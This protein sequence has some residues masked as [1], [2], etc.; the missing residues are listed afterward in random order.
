MDTVALRKLAQERAK[1]FLENEGEYRMGYIE[2]EQPHPLTR[3]L[4]QTYAESTEKGVAMLLS[5]DEEMAKRA[6]ELLLSDGYILFADAVRNTLKNG[7]RVIWSGCGSS[8]RLCMRLEN[9]WRNAMDKLAQMHPE[10]AAD[11]EAL[12][13]RVGSIMT[14]GDYAIIR[15]VECFEDSTNLGYKQAEG[16][17]LTEK[18][19][20]VGVTA[21]AETTSILGSAQCALDV[22][23]KVYMLICSKPGPMLERM[24]RVRKIYT[25][26]NC[27]YL[28]LP[29]GPM[30]LT[31]STRMQSSSFEQLTGAIALEDAV[32][33][34]LTAFGYTAAPT[35]HAW[36]G[37]AY[38]NLIAQLASEKSVAAI[39]DMTRLEESV[40]RAGSVLTMYAE[41]YMLDVMTDTT[42]RPP[43]F[44]T[45]PF[46]SLDMADQPMSWAFVKNPACETR[47]AWQR[48]FAR[49][50]RCIDWN[51]DQ[52]RALGLNQ[53]QIDRIPR[54]DDQALVRFC[55]GCEPLPEREN[56]PGS[57]AMWVGK[58]A[59]PAA[60]HTHA[61]RYAQKTEYTLDHAGLNIPETWMDIYEHLGMKI[62]LNTLSTG[63][64]ASMGRIDGNWMTCLAMSNKKL[65]DRSA[66]I[67]ADVCAIPYEQAMEECFYSSL[68][69][70]AQN[71][72]TPLS[73]AQEA[74]RRL[75]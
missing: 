59:A 56:K 45:P 7:G 19:L 63:V 52:Y 4:S 57:L 31:G 58:S 47:E 53:M 23:A 60:F 18:D 30:A 68:V 69:I 42:E 41:E 15:A 55:I 9:S 25:H 11:F 33:D 70:E 48:C 43:T 51:G 73:P 72:Q 35:D 50:L 26:P 17:K 49:P 21:T 6:Q 16:W 3:K 10:K 12:K 74:I 66:R 62:Y 65:I 13:G 37:N 61:A 14:G 2:A 24:E 46:T 32:Y 67:V 75:S 34:L 22:G 27:S 36:H 5:V 28:F 44:M 40:Y 39:A 1:N 29:C 38:L 64:M 71:G 8:G 54:I 20:L